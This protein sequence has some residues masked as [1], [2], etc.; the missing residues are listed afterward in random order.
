MG[1]PPPTLATDYYQHF[2]VSNIYGATL[3]MH[4]R[5]IYPSHYLRS[6]W[7]A[8]TEL[9][10][11]YNLKMNQFY[12][13][14]FDWINSVQRPTDWLLED[15]YKYYYSRGQNE[16]NLRTAIAFCLKVKIFR[17]DNVIIIS[18]KKLEYNLGFPEPKNT[19]EV[20][21]LFQI[22]IR[23]VFWSNISTVDD[24]RRIQF[25]LV[26]QYRARSIDNYFLH[27][28]KFPMEWP[29]IDLNY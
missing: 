7:M 11:I 22:I 24:E 28:F 29:R 1:K 2:R 20:T 16:E 26:D 21:Q 6:K 23:R 18:G 17:E 27:L 3:K 10:E 14:S 5:L 19:P 9:S 8:G 25:L 4:V 12:S 13:Y 15:R